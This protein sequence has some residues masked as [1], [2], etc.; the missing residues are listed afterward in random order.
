MVQRLKSTADGLQNINFFGFFLFRSD[1][2][3]DTRLLSCFFSCIE[4]LGMGL[5]LNCVRVFEFMSIA[6]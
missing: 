1:R 5:T 2:Y 4:H 3:Q 6:F